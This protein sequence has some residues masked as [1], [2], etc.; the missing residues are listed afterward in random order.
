MSPRV[1]RLA[2]MLAVLTAFGAAVSVIVLS[3]RIALAKIR[4]LEAVEKTDGK[5][6]DD[7]RSALARMTL[8]R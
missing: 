8:L 2:E 3:V 7:G 4:R 5:A 1:L 6:I